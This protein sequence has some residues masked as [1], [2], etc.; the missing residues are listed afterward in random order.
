MDAQARELNL[1][2]SRLASPETAQAQAGEDLPPDFEE[3]IGRLMAL[4]PAKLK[5]L[6]RKQMEG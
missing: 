5:K 2:I 1:S 4:P 6:K 3:V